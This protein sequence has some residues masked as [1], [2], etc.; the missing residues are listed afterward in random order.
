MLVSSVLA[1]TQKV[2]DIFWIL[3]ITIKTISHTFQYNFVLKIINISGH[4]SKKS[5]NGL[6][7]GGNKNIVVRVH[8]NVCST[9]LNYGENP[10]L[11]S[12]WNFYGTDWNNHFFTLGIAHKGLLRRRNCSGGGGWDLQNFGIVGVSRFKNDIHLRL[13]FWSDR[14][15]SFHFNILCLIESLVICL[16]IL[17]ICMQYIN[18]KY[19]W[20]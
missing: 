20:N 10:V 11:S 6:W 17:N 13:Q 16:V 1:G 12:Y 5:D 14:S 19:N 2:Q 15:T 4:L 8:F 3:P 9:S 18:N 7:P